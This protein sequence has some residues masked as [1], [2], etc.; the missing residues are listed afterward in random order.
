MLAARGLLGAYE[1]EHVNGE[2]H[3]WQRRIKIISLNGIRNQLELAR[4]GW[5]RVNPFRTL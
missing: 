4:P 3:A 2:H 5:Q 1:L